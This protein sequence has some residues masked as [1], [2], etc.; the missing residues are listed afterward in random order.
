MENLDKVKQELVLLLNEKIL[1]TEK[2]LKLCKCKKM[3]ALGPFCT[4]YR[5]FARVHDYKFL[6]KKPSIPWKYN[7]LKLHPKSVEAV[8]FDRSKFDL[9][10]TL[11]Q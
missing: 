2:K 5:Y 10:A 7:N 11:L 6:N 9:T 4:N 8:Q 3:P 1:N